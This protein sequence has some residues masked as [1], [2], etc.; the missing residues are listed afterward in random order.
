MPSPAHA[1]CDALPALLDQAQE[2]MACFDAEQQLLWCNP[3]FAMVFG[4][5]AEALRGETLSA[6]DALLA[7]L[8]AGRTATIGPLLQC[9]ASLGRPGAAT[10]RLAHGRE[11][12]LRGQPGPHGGFNLY[13]ASLSAPQRQRHSEFLATAA[14]ELRNPVASLFGF[15][16]LLRS[17]KL[18]PEGLAEVTEILCRQADSLSH[19]VEELLDLARVDAKQG[20][21]FKPQ[22]VSL[23][24]LL[25]EA[26]DSL[27]AE[28]TPQRVQVRIAAS[29]DLLWVDRAKAL[30]VLINILSNA[31]KYSPQ[32][33]P[34]QVHARREKSRPPW[35][36]IEVTDHGIGMSAEQQA[37][38]FERFYR[39]DPSGPIPGTG[40]GMS[41]VQELV[42]LMGGSVRVTSALGQ[43]CR[44]S[45]KLPLATTHI[46]GQKLGE[47]Q[48]A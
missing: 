32:H 28:L 21:D 40:L 2:G 14:H 15:A 12:T 3:A 34:V 36:D 33:T 43:G 30:R 17:R 27:P 42:V 18:K 25:Q 1:L 44:V 7:P 24:A 38:I 19:L 10:V 4:S 46:V 31:L 29:A 8:L 5:T 23:T 22:A 48:G 35:A 41:L 16:Q 37:R 39:A 20:Q 47:K 9:H 6:L 11:W 26:R 45:L 13:L